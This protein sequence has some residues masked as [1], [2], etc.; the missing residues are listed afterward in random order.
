MID[1][2]ARLR[3]GRVDDASVLAELVDY[4]GEGLPSYLW[5]KMYYT[6]LSF[7]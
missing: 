2:D 5:S 4:A 6:A 1:R 3:P 7:F